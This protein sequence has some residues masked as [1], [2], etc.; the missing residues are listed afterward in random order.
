MDILTNLGHLHYEMHD[1]KS[2]I[3]YFELVLELNATRIEDMGQALALACHHNGDFHAAEGFY[4]RVEKR[5]ADFYFNFGVTLQNLGKARALLLL[6]IRF[7]LM[8]LSCCRL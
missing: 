6:T 8:T 7:L 4:R 5:S 1:F 2:S 3:A